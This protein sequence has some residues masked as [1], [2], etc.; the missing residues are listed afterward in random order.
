MY[1]VI[2]TG[3]KQY[4]V[5]PGKTVVV[6]KLDGDEGAKVEFDQV[7]LVSSGDGGTVSIGK[8]TVAGA[9][10]S[11][12]IVEQGR[13]DK[14]IIFKFRRRKN[15]VRRNGHRQDYTAVKINN[16]SG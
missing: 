2:Q 9:K 7:L 13:G 14:L 16:I 11:G 1:A 8:P 15:Y 12:E 10:V 6:E 5:E 3:G 4:R